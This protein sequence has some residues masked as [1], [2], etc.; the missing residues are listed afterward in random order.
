MKGNLIA[1][2]VCLATWILLAF[3]RPVG[4]GIIN[5]LWAASAVLWIRWYAL[6]TALTVNSER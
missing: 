4:L 6:R 1:S 2:L 5:L 3:L